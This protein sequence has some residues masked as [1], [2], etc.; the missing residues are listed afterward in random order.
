MNE[1][2]FIWKFLNQAEIEKDRYSSF[3]LAIRDA[4]S[5]SGRDPESGEN[6]LDILT[7]EKSFLSPNSFIG[8]INYLLILEMIGK[9][10]KIKNG[11]KIKKNNSIYKALHQFYN[12]DEKDINTIIALRN[13][14]AH[15]YS[16]VNIPYNEIENNDKRH[17]FILCYS[18]NVN[19]IE[20][21]TKPWDGQ[22]SNKLDSSSTK[23][24]I[25]LL[26]ELI[27][28]IIRKVKYLYKNN[29]I[30]LDLDNGID[31]LKTCFTI[32]F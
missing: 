22:F 8:L 12:L 31:E 19:I 27:E 32:R 18:S 15:N 14:L 9:I 10:F 11:S 25:I 23:I 28:E 29:L 7:N 16:L 17:K 4:R 26:I 5:I 20:Y 1:Q 24:G 30:E 21:P 6:G 3:V 2:E 13:S